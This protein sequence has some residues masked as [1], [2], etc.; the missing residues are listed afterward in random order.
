MIRATKVR[1]TAGHCEN[2]IITYCLYPHNLKK[3]I[4]AHPGNLVSILGP[5][6]IQQLGVC[7]SASS[8]EPNRRQ[9]GVRQLCS[10]QKPLLSPRNPQLSESQLKWSEELSNTNAHPRMIN[11]QITL[12]KE[13]AMTYWTSD[14]VIQSISSFPLIFLVV[15]ASFPPV[16][17]RFGSSWFYFIAVLA[18][19]IR[20]HKWLLSRRAWWWWGFVSP[21]SIKGWI[22]TSES[23]FL[24]AAAVC[25]L[26][27]VLFLNSL[28]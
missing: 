17:S 25:W 14:P 18:L 9:S 24:L 11:L 7:T 16:S 10:C 5:R 28:Q 20:I 4:Y 2:K 1:L 3:N 15:S 19:L 21:A 13:C 8:V 27:I 6:S 22:C 23:L 12:F 26:W